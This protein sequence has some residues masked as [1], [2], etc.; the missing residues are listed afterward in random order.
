MPLAN[1]TGIAVRALRAGVG[2]SISLTLVCGAARADGAKTERSDST[3]HFRPSIGIEVNAT[4]NVR[5]QATN[6]DSDV[7]AVPRIGLD[8]DAK[9]DDLDVFVNAGLVYHSFFENSSLDRFSGSLLAH[10]TLTAVPDTVFVD[11]NAQ[12]SD[13]FLNIADVSATGLPNGAPQARIFN[14][15][16]S[17]YV[18]SVLFGEVDTLIRARVSAIRTDSYDLSTPTPSLGNSL[19][20]QAGAVFGN[21]ERGRVVEWRLSGDYTREERDGGREFTSSDG[22][23]GLTFHVTPRINLLARGGY[24]E[25][26]DPGITPIR[27]AIWAG[28]ALYK[29]GDASFVTGEYRHR[30]DR[31]SWFGQ[32]ELAMSSNLFVS[33]NYEER[34]ESQQLRLG[35]SLTDLFKQQASI[36]PPPTPAPFSLGEDF[37]D[38]VFYARD[39]YLGARYVTPER[40]FSLAA[41]LSRR[42]FDALA[43][44]DRTAGLTATYSERFHTKLTLNLVG[45]YNAR[46]DAPIG[47]VPVDRYT[48]SSGLVYL[49]SETASARLQYT[50]SLTDGPSTITENLISASMAKSF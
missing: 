38:Q 1:S 30:F 50:W 26:T 15:Q 43:T 42:E 48:A 29:L 25:L 28:G 22:L 16:L 7:V 37:V 9:T 40:S 35:R 18:K 12:I 33:A 3:F 11:A 21:G 4:D 8:I 24:E 20:Y 41:K 6:K 2:V 27:G 49:L 32:A 34:V 31:D 45:D 14:Y 23:L 44:D 5:R 19:A 47:L 13:E 39:A 10:A 17:P 46:L 36:P